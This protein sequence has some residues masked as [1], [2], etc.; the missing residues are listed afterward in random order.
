MN[1]EQHDTD[2]DE[3]NRCGTKKYATH[4][5]HTNLD[6]KST[7]QQATTAMELLKMSRKPSLVFFR[8][9]RSVKDKPAFG[10]DYIQIS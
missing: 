2:Q 10:Q 3:A 6:N 8:A 7:V 4:E 9:I 5:N 1:S